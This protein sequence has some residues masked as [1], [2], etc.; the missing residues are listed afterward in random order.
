MSDT[1]VIQATKRDDLGKGASRRLRR[2]EGLMPAVIYGAGEEPQSISIPHKDLFK[3]TQNEALFASVLEVNVDGKATSA[4]LKDLQRH[5]ARQELIHADFLRV[6]QNKALQVHVPLHFINEEACHGVKM[7]GG[8]IQHSMIE[9]EISCLPANL[10]EFI[11]VDMLAVELG[12]I[13][14]LSDIILGE[15]VESVALSHGE[16]HDLPVATIVAPK[17]GD[18]EATAEGAAEGE[19]E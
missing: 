9:I 12:Q 1:I 19:G 15:G 4:I 6:D 7:Q 8:R 10:P 17:G 16:D 14:H 13:L 2:N 3:A 18:E 5:P 11:E